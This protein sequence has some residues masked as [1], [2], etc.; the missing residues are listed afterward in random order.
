[1]SYR[2]EV[3]VP[4]GTCGTRVLYYVRITSTVLYTDI[5]C[6]ILLYWK[7]KKKKN[8]FLEEV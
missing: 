3:E 4:L 7:L 1:M 6:I 2:V 8:C 5:N